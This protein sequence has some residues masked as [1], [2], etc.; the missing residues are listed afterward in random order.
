MQ[1]NEQAGTPEGRYNTSLP[2]QDGSHVV[3]DGGRPKRKE[4][5][6]TQQKVAEFRILQP[7][8]EQID[9]HRLLEEY[10]IVDVLAPMAVVYLHNDLLDRGVDDQVDGV[11]GEGRTGVRNPQDQRRADDAVVEHVPGDA[12]RRRILEDHTFWPRCCRYRAVEQRN[13]VRERDRQ[14]G[15]GEDLEDEETEKQCPRSVCFS[16]HRRMPGLSTFDDGETLGGSTTL[17]VS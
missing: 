8:N 10:A 4:E 7:G 17:K 3:E 14:C 9:F 13:G 15:R 12:G 6:L 2:S 5:L 16:R 1:K 11:H